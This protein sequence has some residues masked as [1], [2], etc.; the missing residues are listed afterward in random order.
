[1]QVNLYSWAQNLHRC[2]MTWDDLEL[3]RRIV[4]AGTLTQ[5]G[6]ALGV[7]QTTAARRLARIER[8]L[9]MTLFDR[10][11]GRLVATPVLA[12]AM[13]HL[14]AMAEAAHRSQAALRHTKAALDGRVRIS[15]LSFVLTHV[16]A[17]MVGRLHDAH[18]LITLDFVSEA[19]NVN[20]ER[21]EADISIRLARPTDEQAIARRLGAVRFRLYRAAGAAHAGAP[22]VRYDDA[23]AHLPEMQLLDR[24]RPKARVV[25]KSGQLEVLI[26]AAVALGGELM[27]PEPVGD[28]EPRL[29][30]AGD[31]E[32]VADREL[33]LLIHPDRRRADNVAA[34]VR[35]IEAAFREHPGLV[36]G[37]RPARRG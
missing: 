11:G 17:P 34:V 16:L 36:T 7:D 18:P 26:E 8:Q 19:R 6:R 32:A 25:L 4:D 1:M 29:M 21:R 30:R 10:I 5:A 35:W 28:G 9:G 33:F 20:F 31:A 23:F 15:S 37:S 3:L 2:R 13:E 14:K 27:L 24:L 12:G 22:V